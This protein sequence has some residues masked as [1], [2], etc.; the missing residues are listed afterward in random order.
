MLFSVKFV[1]EVAIFCLFIH[2]YDY[3]FYVNFPMGPRIVEQISIEQNE[4]LKNKR[5]SNFI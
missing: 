2:L 1:L 4:F 3:G 5:I